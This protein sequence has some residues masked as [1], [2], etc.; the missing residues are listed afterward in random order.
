MKNK[1]GDTLLEFLVVIAI[2]SIIAILMIPVVQGVRKAVKKEKAERA[3]SSQDGRYYQPRRNAAQETQEGAAAKGYT[4]VIKKTGESDEIRENV[5]S[6][7]I[8]GS[9]ITIELEK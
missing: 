9:T 2:I 8:E 5:K 1:K 7:T 3:K 4:L 6:V